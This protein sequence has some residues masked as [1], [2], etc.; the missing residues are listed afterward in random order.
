MMH[1]I[2]D[3]LVVAI[4]VAGFYGLFELYVRRKERLA[5]IEKLGDKIEGRIDANVLRTNFY[6]PFA[7]SSK[8]SF[9]ALKL[10]C[11][12]AGIGL[13]LLIAF[14]I[15]FYSSNEYA[16]N[17][18]SDMNDWYRHEI[19]GTIYGAAVLLC[20]GIGLIVAFVIELKIKAK[21]NNQ[22]QTPARQ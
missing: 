16:I 6:S 3:P 21:D 11:L 7:R 1:F 18:N 12:L 19:V 14:L 9:G 2:S 10:G 17:M 20:G 22:N 5:I 15:T 13:G 8:S 4:C